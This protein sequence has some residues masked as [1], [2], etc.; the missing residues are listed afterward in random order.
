MNKMRRAYLKGE[1]VRKHNYTDLKSEL[2]RR[3]EERMKQLSEQKQSN[4]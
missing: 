1:L 3:V 2:N 4:Q